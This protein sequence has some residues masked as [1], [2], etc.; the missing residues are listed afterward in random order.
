VDQD[1]KART[2]RGEGRTPLRAITL[3]TSRLRAL[4]LLPVALSTDQRS[5]LGVIERQPHAI[6]PP[7]D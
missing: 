2:T 4:H 5:A 7:M 6:A 1:R 3:S